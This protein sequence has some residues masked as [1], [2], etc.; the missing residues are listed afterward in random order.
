MQVTETFSDGL[1][2]AFTV[3]LPSAAVEGRRA[4]RL[5]EI[6]KTLSLPGFRP[7]KVPPIVVRQRYGTAVTA[8]VVEES[9]QNA[10]QQVLDDRGL[11]PATQPSVDLLNRDAVAS[12]GLTSDLE[13]KMD[14]EVLP[15]ITLPDFAAI[16]LTRL[17][18]EAGDEVLDKALHDIAR[19]NRTLEDIGADELGGRG[20]ETGEVVVADYTGRIDGEAFP[21]GTQADTPIEAGG[22]G[23]IPSFAEQIVGMT[24]GETRT[25]T[26]T[27]PENYG[28]KS[29]AGRQAE[30]EV[31]AKAIKRA[32]QPA[33]DD[34]FA[35]TL[36]FDNLDELKDFLRG[37]IQSEYDQLSRTRLKREL[38]DRL[39]ELVSFA[40]PPTLVDSEFNQIWARVEADRK[41]GSLDEEDKAKDDDTLRAEY[42]AIAERRV[43][44]GLL[45]AEVGRLNDVGVT[46]EELS[47]AMRAEAANYP[48]QEEKILEFYRKNPRMADTLRGPI[49]EEKAIDVVIGRARVSERPASPEELAADPEE[50]P[51]K[52]AAPPDASPDAQSP[53]TPP[54]EAP[55]E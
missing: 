25:I 42:R 13:F 17:K 14:V 24:P 50:T 41:T 2:R 38:L 15:E 18:A 3:V 1:K 28:T 8:E 9:V 20:A 22:E 37:R 31:A 6:G 43:R 54:S 29:L 51:A 4:E 44:L 40:L 16:E 45:L 32:K 55:A 27:F 52:A 10:V 7:G 36:S 35:Q 47:R 48:G 34:A 49:F 11:R 46:A 53:E 26:V 12:T 39:S 30:F 5:A 21:G 19:R 33:I 23:F